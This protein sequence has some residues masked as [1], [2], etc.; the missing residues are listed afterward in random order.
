MLWMSEHM[1]TIVEDRNFS[2]SSTVFR[3]SAS[4]LMISLYLTLSFPVMMPFKFC[5]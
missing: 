3:V 4:R 1:E 2:G 5:P